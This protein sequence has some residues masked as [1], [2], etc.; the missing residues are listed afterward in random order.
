MMKEVLLEF[1]QGDEVPNRLLH[2]RKNGVRLQ[3]AEDERRHH[4]GLY[5]QLYESPY[6]RL[7]L[8]VSSR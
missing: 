7:S 3:I 8:E 5:R 1:E 4:I 2:R 6:P